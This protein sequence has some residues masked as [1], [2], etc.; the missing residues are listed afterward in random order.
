MFFFV[1]C[2]YFSNLNKKSGQFCYLKSIRLLM[3]SNSKDVVRFHLCITSYYDCFYYYNHFQLKADLFIYFF[4]C[5]N[6]LDEHKAA[7]TTDIGM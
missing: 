4:L 5:Y 1:E 3:W 6:N 2:N 7:L